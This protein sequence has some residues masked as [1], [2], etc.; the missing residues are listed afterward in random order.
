MAGLARLQGFWGN[1]LQLPAPAIAER[2]TRPLGTEQ[3]RLDCLQGDVP[4]TQQQPLCFRGQITAT[5]PCFTV[6]L[7]R[8]G[9][10]S[11]PDLNSQGCI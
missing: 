11:L 3:K 6:D 4:L 9:T 8:M 1:S 10:R 2:L 7:G 5:G